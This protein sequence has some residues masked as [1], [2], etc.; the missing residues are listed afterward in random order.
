MSD[1]A[2]FRARQDPRPV[3]RAQA[4]SQRLAREEADQIAAR[5]AR[6]AQS[7]CLTCGCAYIGD[8]A[9]HAESPEHK[10]IVAASRAW[11]R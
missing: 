3:M 1:D 4:E 7:Q 2:R 9:E 8:I 5:A 11:P 10:A 6:I